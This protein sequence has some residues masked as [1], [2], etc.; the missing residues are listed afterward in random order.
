MRVLS[1]ERYCAEI[2]TQTD[3]LRSRIDDADLTVAVPTCPSWNLGQ[4][5]RHLGGGHRWVEEIVRT[6]ATQPPSDEHFRDLS[7]YTDE[8]PAVLGPW[9]TKGAVQLADTLRAAGPDA[10]M[11]TPVPGQTAEFFARRFAHETLIHGADAT[12]ALGGDFTVDRE[13]ALDAFDEWMELGSL[14][15]MFEYH[16]EMRE[17]LGPGRTLHFHATDTPPETSAEWLIDLTGD[18]IVW[19]RAHEKAAVAVRGRLADLLLLVYRRLP[20]HSE[21]FEIFGDAQL[22]DFWLERVGFG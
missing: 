7:G 11:W 9:L 17:L 22:L 20:A 14:P 4:L 1:Y 10:Q 15:E 5:L 8:D 6:R 12:L 19:R 13:V 18:T 21:A 16:P 2:V 3:L